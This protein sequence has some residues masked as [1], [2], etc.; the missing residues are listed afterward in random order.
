M[1][2]KI[3]M[4]LALFGIP[5]VPT[6]WALNDIPR[7]RFGGRRRKLKWFL[8]TAAIPCFGALAYILLA[9]RQTTPCEPNLFETD[10]DQTEVH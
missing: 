8:L 6:I 10:P 7:R 1:P 2:L 5:M 3:L 4:I 9:R